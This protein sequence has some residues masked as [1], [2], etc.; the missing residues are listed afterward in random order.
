L[1]F[2]EDIGHVDFNGIGSYWFIILPMK[3]S[4][5]RHSRFHQ[6]SE[7]LDWFKGFFTGQP[8]IF[9]GKIYGFPN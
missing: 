4:I 5:L 3:I 2:F 6:S 8:H 7:S 9:D 1:V